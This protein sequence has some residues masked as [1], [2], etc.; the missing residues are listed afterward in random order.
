MESGTASRPGLNATTADFTIG[1]GVDVP[2]TGWVSLRAHWVDPVDD[3]AEPAPSTRSQRVV[4]GTVPLAYDKDATTA[5]VEVDHNF[6]DGF[7]H[8]VEVSARAIARFTDYF[9]DPHPVDFSG[10]DVLALGAPVVGRTFSLQERGTGR[11][12]REGQDYRLDAEAGTI[13][14]SP[15]GRIDAATPLTARYAPGPNRLS[16]LDGGKPTVTVVVP[17]STIPPAPV[18]TSVQPAHRRVQQRRWGARMLRVEGRRLRLRLARPWLVTGDGE[19]LA[20][21]VDREPVGL[22]ATTR[23]GRD[24]INT[25]VPDGSPTLDSFPSADFVR[26]GQTATLPDG[27]SVT[28]DIA[29]HTPVF[30]EARGDWTVDLIVDTPDYRPAIRLALARFQPDSINGAALSVVSFLDVVRLG[31]DR[32]IAITRGPSATRQSPTV[33]VSV[34]GADHGGRLNAAGGTAFNQVRV[35]VQEADASISDPDLR[36]R[37]TGTVVELT[38]TAGSTETT[39]DGEVFLPPALGPLRLLVEELEPVVRDDGTGEGAIDDVDLV[40]V[41]TVV[42][43]EGVVG[44]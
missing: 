39:W 12:F 3:P 20:V 8:A 4:L 18:V 43:P 19:R 40:N 28:V 41:E 5:E 26:R 21:L 37:S 42:L 22:P 25:G 13:E 11:A 34:T 44:G 6:R 24:P 30:D 17:N 35:T 33:A 38:R 14:R 10:G 32:D 27:T 9:V 29:G 16:S 7:R 1:M 23:F 2:A 15:S 31:V 36:W